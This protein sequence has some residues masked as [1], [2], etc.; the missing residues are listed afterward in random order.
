M[1]TS[2]ETILSAQGLCKS[3]N[4]PS[5]RIDVLSDVSLELKSGEQLAITGASG[6]GKTTLLSLLAGL[7]APDKGTISLAGHRIEK[8]DEDGLAK[9]RGKWMGIVFQKFHLIPSLTALENVALPLQILNDEKAEEKAAALL[10]QVG[11]RDRAHHLPR[12]LSG[13]ESQRVAIARALAPSPRLILADEPSGNLDT[14][15]GEFVMD[16]LFKL[17]SEHGAALALVTHDLSLAK[18]CGRHIVLQQGRVQ[19][20]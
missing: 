20:T 2:S 7:D 10:L 15:T 16:M 13:G 9:M 3:Y 1:S 17:S 5:G 4:M 6:S 12:E 11:L 18:R 14:K 8:M 19:S